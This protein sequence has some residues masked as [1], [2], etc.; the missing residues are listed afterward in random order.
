MFDLRCGR[1]FRTVESM[2]ISEKASEL[3]MPLNVASARGKTRGAS[4]RY[5][6]CRLGPEEF[7]MWSRLQHWRSWIPR[8]AFQTLRTL[9]QP[10]IKETHISYH[11][12]GLTVS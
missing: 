6:A 11:H 10:R 9:G 12:A 1:G 3:Q 4:D 5:G 8:K 7:A 2:D